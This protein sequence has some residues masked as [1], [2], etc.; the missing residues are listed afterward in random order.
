MKTIF[1]ATML[2]VSALVAFSS[3]LREQTSLDIKDIPGTAKVTGTLVICEG[4]DYV[5]GK[6]V[7]LK[8]P[9]ANTEVTI[10]IDNSSFTNSGEGT[11]DYTAV[12]NE[13]GYFEC[14]IPAVDAGVNFNVSVP[15]FVGDY[16]K[17]KGAKEGQVV[18]EKVNGVYA[19][20]KSVSYSVNPGDIMD[21]YLEYMHEA[22]NKAWYFETTVPLQVYVGK[23]WAAPTSVK[24]QDI[25]DGSKEYEHNGE[26]LPAEDVAVKLDVV[27]NKLNG[28]KETLVGFSDSKG[29]V[30]FDIP[31]ENV[32]E[33]HSGAVSLSITAEEHKG[34][35]DFTCYTWVKNYDDPSKSK[36]G[37]YDLLAGTYTFA[38]RVA[39][40]KST[41]DFRF[42]TPV[43]KLI[44]EVAQVNEDPGILTL[45]RED[46]EYIE[47]YRR[48]YL[49]DLEDEYSEHW[50]LK[51]FEV[52]E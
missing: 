12:T 5:D 2:L 48:T 20:D 51:K 34:E 40:C 28:H 33:M 44:M 27:Y 50:T 14:V 13:A 41:Y 29:F 19:V 39:D 7:F 25:I 4:T 23:A 15:S 37:S 32:D 11:T 31:A 24:K 22:S 52:E 3:C 45:V 47:N 43:V 8:K 17:I 49:D 21:V 9:S 6:Y 42:F 30:Q 35:T 26:V 36:E 16:L 18:V 38:F 46:Y 10:R 1:K